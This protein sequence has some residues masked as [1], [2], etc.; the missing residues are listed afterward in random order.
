MG[1]WT[2]DLLVYSPC[3]KGFPFLGILS[4][5]FTVRFR[6]CAF[7][8]FLQRPSDASEL[9]FHGTDGCHRSYCTSLKLLR[10]LPH[11]YDVVETTCGTWASCTL[12]RIR[13][14]AST[15]PAG[16]TYRG[17]SIGVLV[18][19]CGLSGIPNRY[20]ENYDCGVECNIE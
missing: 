13:M 11:K 18:T 20:Y 15:W 10:H 7:F 2:W 17:A 8:F 1:C 5:L 6:S 4:F 19:C 12:N 3:G 14:A 16:V 9:S